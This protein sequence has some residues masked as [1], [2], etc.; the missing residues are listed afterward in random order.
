VALHSFEAN[1]ASEFPEE[2]PTGPQTDL[3]QTALAPAPGVVS[4]GEISLRTES[5]ESDG[6]GPSRVLRGVPRPIA[7][8]ILGVSKSYG[9]T[10]ILQNVSLT[11][12]E[13][14]CL[15]LIG[16]NGA[17][18]STLFNVISGRQQPSEGAVVL[19]GRRIDQATPQAIQGLGLAR[20]FQT[21]NLFLNLT[22]AD[23]LRC[24]V[25][26]ARGLSD[27]LRLS[28]RQTKAVRER[29]HALLQQ[30]DLQSRAHLVA[31]NLSY[32]DQRALEL[33]LALA[34]DPSVLLL[35]E[36][37][38]GMS[39]AETDKS[40]ALIRRAARG[41]SLLIVE[42]DMSVVFGLADKIAVLAQGELIACDSPAA[43]RSNPIVQAAYLGHDADNIA[44]PD[45]TASVQN[46]AT[47]HA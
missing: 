37:T 46:G 15:A 4:H 39:P 43:V 5:S 13:G 32:A 44:H 8:Q 42:H 35:D 16:P 9:Q 12:A 33:G 41:K 18:K 7:L 34:G 17:G 3:A 22:V 14:E 10:N 36:P 30:L 47:A 24:A 19:G 28:G 25:L 20:S 1:T 27:R 38:A 45:R 31:R 2:I 6:A 21:S 11:L 23:S 29:V 40:I 26:G